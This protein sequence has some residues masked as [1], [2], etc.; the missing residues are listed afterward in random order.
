MRPMISLSNPVSTHTQC[1]QYHPW[2]ESIPHPGA[3]GRLALSRDGEDTIDSFESCILLDHIPHDEYSTPTFE[4][5]STWHRS[6]IT[7]FIVSRKLSF[8]VTYTLFILMFINFTRCFP[9]LQPDVKCERC[10]L[11][12]ITVMSDEG[13]G[14]PESTST[15]I[16]VL[17]NYDRTS[18]INSPGVALKLRDLYFGGNTA[19]RDVLKFYRK[20]TSCSCLK[21][22]H[23]EARKDIQKMGGCRLLPLSKAKGT[24]HIVGMQQMRGCS[25]LLARVSSRRLAKSQGRRV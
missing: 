16:M 7:V 23:L 22:M 2:L 4:D 18:V 3:P 6:S 17:E 12:L 19:K 10:H 11:Q 5:E 25:V 14:V 13:H 15:L 1:I 20:R 8:V 24:F 21:K 9:L